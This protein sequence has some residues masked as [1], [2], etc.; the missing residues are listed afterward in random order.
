MPVRRTCGPRRDVLHRDA[1]P[2]LCTVGFDDR[3]RGALVLNSTSDDWCLYQ[4]ENF[5]GEWRLMEPGEGRSP[6]RRV[7]PGGVLVAAGA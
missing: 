1:V 7:R 3:A 5:G 2:G 4:N 6:H